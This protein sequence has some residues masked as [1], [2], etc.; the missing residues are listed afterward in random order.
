MSIDVETRRPQ[1]SN[2][3]G[4]LSGPAIRPIA[5]RMVYE[6]SSAINIPI[7]GMGGICTARDVI[8]FM[9]A[10]ASAV[11]IGTANF[12]DPLIWPK[13]EDGLVRYLDHHKYNTVKDLVG[14]LDLSD[15]NTE[16]TSS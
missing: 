1:L 7:I 11:Q 5:V 2:I 13:L 12:E 6:C 16:W 3:F 14:T 9:I 10:G 15:R 4:G 8:E